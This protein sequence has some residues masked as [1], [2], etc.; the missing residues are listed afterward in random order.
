MVHLVVILEY[1]LHLGEIPTK[2]VYREAD[3]CL[4]GHICY[5][6]LMIER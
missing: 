4:A 2:P 6:T 5:Y 1:M 3:P